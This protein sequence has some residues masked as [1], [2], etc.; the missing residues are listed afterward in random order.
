MK[1]FHN[2]PK[3]NHKNVTKL[4]KAKK[5]LRFLRKGNIIESEVFEQSSKVKYAFSAS[6]LATLS[7]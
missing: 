7:Q 1:Y 6:E 4:K 5:L 2:F 3:E